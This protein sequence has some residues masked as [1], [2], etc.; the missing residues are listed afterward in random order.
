[1]RTSAGAKSGPAPAPAPSKRPTE[2]N[3]PALSKLPS[4]LLELFRALALTVK[5]TLTQPDPKGQRKPK[6]Q[7]YSLP[8]PGFKS[9]R[10]ARERLATFESAFAGRLAWAPF[11]DSVNNDGPM[12][13]NAYPGRAFI[14]RVTNEGDAN[15][16]AAAATHPGDKPNSPAEAVKEWYGL[17]HDSLAVGEDDEVLKLAQE[18]V[19]VSGWIGDPKDP[20]DSI[21]DARD[22][23]IG[24]TAAEMPSTIL[25][26][27]RGNKKT[28]P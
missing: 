3:F 24:L 22:Y 16:E 2:P 1:M 7:D 17:G 10:D 15:L 5:T 21:F 13:L 9:W 20:K 18:T 27:N 23:G 26:L 28:K 12:S 11:N 25:S 6:K 8:W 4:T 19:T 14:E